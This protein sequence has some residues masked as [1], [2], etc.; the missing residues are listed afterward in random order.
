[1]AAG[2]YSRMSLPNFIG[3]AIFL[4][5]VG[6]A[7]VP[8]TLRRYPISSPPKAISPPGE[9]AFSHLAC[10]SRQLWCGTRPHQSTTFFRP[11]EL[12]PTGRSCLSSFGTQ[13]GTTLVPKRFE[14]A[15]PHLTGRYRVAVPARAAEHLPMS[16]DT[17]FYSALTPTLTL[18]RLGDN[19]GPATNQV[20]AT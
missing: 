9:I 1:M 18:L 14:T 5:V 8:G 15:L 16:L 17:C 10:P 3:L 13:P 12:L 6:T 19:Q 20:A 7:R 2:L 4:V 11:R